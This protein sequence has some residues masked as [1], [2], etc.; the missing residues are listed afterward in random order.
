MLRALM[1]LGTARAF[2]K[3][4]RE[5]LGAGRPIPV[6]CGQPID[7]DERIC[8]FPEGSLVHREVTAYLVSEVLGGASC[9]ALGCG[10]VRWVRE[11]CNSCKRQAASSA[12]WAWCRPMGCPRRAGNRFSRV[13]TKAAGS[14][15][16]VAALGAGAAPGSAGQGRFPLR[17][18]ICRPFP[19]RC[20]EALQFSAKEVPVPFFGKQCSIPVASLEPILCGSTELV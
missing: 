8:S 15:P 1:P 19:S 2:A 14:S 3:H 13:R 9:R 5:V 20:S 11:W 6:F 4:T 10:T 18:E 12:R 17:V 7:A 16:E